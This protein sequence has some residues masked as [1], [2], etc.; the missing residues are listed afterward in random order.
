MIFSLFLL[1]FAMQYSVERFPIANTSARYGGQIFHSSEVP[2]RIV[3][4]SKS[5][6]FPMRGDLC[7]ARTSDRARHASC[8]TEYCFFNCRRYTHS[9]HI[10][11]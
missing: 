4:A 7:N 5:G 11:S 8:R 10:V 3:P 2:A 9:R 6:K 1:K